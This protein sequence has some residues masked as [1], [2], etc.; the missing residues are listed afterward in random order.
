M[1]SD[2]TVTLR[3][4]RVV[5]VTFVRSALIEVLRTCSAGTLLAV[6]GA[7]AMLPEANLVHEYVEFLVRN[8]GE[9]REESSR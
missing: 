2:D 3:D 4:G 8:E 9:D 5:P 7:V 6:L 1:Q